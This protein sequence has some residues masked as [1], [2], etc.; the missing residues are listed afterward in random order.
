MWTEMGR[1]GIRLQRVRTS[2]GLWEEEDSEMF[3]DFKRVEAKSSM[4]YY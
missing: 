3:F 2:L 4:G 1:G